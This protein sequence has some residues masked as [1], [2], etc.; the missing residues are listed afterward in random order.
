MSDPIFATESEL[1]ELFGES[2]RKHAASAPPAAAVRLVR[3]G[4][5]SPSLYD[6]ESIPD[7]D[8]LNVTQTVQAVDRVFEDTAHYP[9]FPWPAL[10]EMAGAMCPEDLWLVAG[11]T[12]N[13]KSLF[14]LNL[15]DQLVEAGRRVLYVGLEQSPKILRIK[16]ACLRAGVPPKRI[17]AATPEEKATT[18][19][20]AMRADVCREIDV[21][22]EPAFRFG[23]HFSAARFVT[24]AKLQAWTEWAVDMGCDLVIVDHIDR[25]HHGDG[26]NAFHE[27]SETVRLAKELAVEHRIVMLMASQVG[28]PGDPLQKFMPPAISDLRGAGTKEEEADAVLAVYRPL[29]AGTT[30]G[31]M[32]RV[33]QG[34]AEESAIYEPDTMAVRVLKHRLD[35]SVSLAKPCLLNVAR[36]RLFPRGPEL[37]YSIRGRD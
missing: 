11:R 33:R 30:E 15:F 10:D 24:R 2:G 23:A 13:G 32:K 6:V 14:L 18:A 21:Q 34:L 28:R 8:T 27:L 3:P 29:K 16:W 9:R 22:S 17:L 19:Y 26:R 20:E 36:G 25:M 5:P 1:D 12:G 35:G 4:D 31:E 37:P 7:A